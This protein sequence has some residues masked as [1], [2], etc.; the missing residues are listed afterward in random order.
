MDFRYENELL[1][2]IDLTGELNNTIDQ[3]LCL[4]S[5]D[6]DCMRS[7][8]YSCDKDPVTSTQPPTVPSSGS[9]S[10]SGTPYSGDGSDMIDL[11]N[12]GRPD[13]SEGDDLDVINRPSSDKFDERWPTANPD[14]GPILDIYDNFTSHILKD[15]TDEED[16]PTAID[17]LDQ[18]GNPVNQTGSGGATQPTVQ[19]EPSPTE[20][21][22]FVTMT[23]DI[24][25]SPMLVDDFNVSGSLSINRISLSILY[26]TLAIF[27]LF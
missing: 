1:E 7:V 17:I 11:E 18:D 27:Y 23:E 19:I 4:N 25:E 5:D 14:D 8:S 24:T 9:G 16:V 13:K 21:T 3:Y 15:Q 20:G 26:M 10:G 6:E 2:L 22:T 12:S